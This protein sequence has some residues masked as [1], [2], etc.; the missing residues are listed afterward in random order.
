MNSKKIALITGGSRGLGRDM[1][2][3]I[4]NEVQPKQT[5]IKEKQLRVSQH[6]A[7]WVNRKI[8]AVLLHFYA[9]LKRVG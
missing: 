2:I 8:L 3:G 1:A 4:A 7:E 6:W 9:L 5:R